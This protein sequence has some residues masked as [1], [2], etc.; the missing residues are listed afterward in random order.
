M[1]SCCEYCLLFIKK[2]Y[3]RHCTSKCLKLD[4]IVKNKITHMSYI[5]KI[6]IFLNNL[7]IVNN[8]LLQ[9]IKKWINDISLV[10]LKQ[11][12]KKIKKCIENH[13]F[14]YLY[15]FVNF[16]IFNDISLNYRQKL[17][18]VLYMAIY[19]NAVIYIRY[20][21]SDYYHHPHPMRILDLLDLCSN[22]TFHI[23]NQYYYIMEL[24]QECNPSQYLDCII[25]WKHYENLYKNLNIHSLQDEKILTL[26]HIAIEQIH[27]YKVKKFVYL[28]KKLNY[29]RDIYRKILI[30]I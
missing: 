12:V 16:K 24:I 27:N 7:D 11:M 21:T 28:F 4:T 30:F 8:D 9:K 18:K 25:Y 15:N 20:L 2:K 17:E 5:Y 22:I 6:N 23:L 14:L 1:K 19:N 29:N 26:I 10:V 3:I 13:K